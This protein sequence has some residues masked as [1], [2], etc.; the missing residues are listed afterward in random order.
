[1]ALVVSGRM[2]AAMEAKGCRGV[3]FQEL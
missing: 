1:V 3:V 2:R